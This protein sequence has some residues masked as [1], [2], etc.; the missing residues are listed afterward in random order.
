MFP[1]ANNHL[2][3]IPKHYFLLISPFF[4]ITAPIEA[5]AKY[6]PMPQSFSHR[7]AFSA[8]NSRKQKS[9]LVVLK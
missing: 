5:F 9:N 7:T 1:I 4:L 2:F 8:K 6:N 3:R